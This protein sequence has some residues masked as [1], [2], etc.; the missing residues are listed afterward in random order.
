VLR[1][2][3]LGDA[4]DMRRWRNHDDV[5]AVSLT[6]HEI[7]ADEHASWIGAALV[8]PTR[9]VLIYEHA[10]T[11][12]GVV[13]FTGIRAGRASWGYFLDIDGLGQRDETLPA[14]LRICREAVDYAFDDL[15]LD[16][17]T[18]E[19]LAHNTAVRQMNRLVGFTEC[20]SRSVTRAGEAVECLSI[21]MRRSERKSTSRK[22]HV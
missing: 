13:T 17:L 11:P 3:T 15:G 7:S 22:E 6:T 4:D 1:L 18:G 19:V 14:W 20:G 10:G 21:M 5:R 16:E 12:S 8:D 2:A 9:R